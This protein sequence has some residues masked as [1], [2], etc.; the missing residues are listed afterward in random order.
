MSNNND[1]QEFKIKAVKILEQDHKRNL[2]LLKTTYVAGISSYIRNKRK[3]YVLE[4]NMM[5]QNY[6]GIVQSLTP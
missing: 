2:G 5:V 6:D 1:T 3:R 4:Q